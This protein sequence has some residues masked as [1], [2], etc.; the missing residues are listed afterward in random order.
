VGP[1]R[2][3]FFFSS[4][5]PKP[6]EICKFKMD[7]FPCS[8]NSKILHEVVLEHYKQLCKLCGLQIANKNHGKNPGIDSIFESSMNFKGLQTFWKNSDKFSLDLIFTKVNLVWA[9]LYVRI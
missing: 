5:F 1:T 9:H 8:K 6:S 2:F 4:N 7:A 3:N